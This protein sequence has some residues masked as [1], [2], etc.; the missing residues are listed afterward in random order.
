MRSIS[1]AN[2]KGGCGKTTTAIN[3]SACL[4]FS[5]KRVLL[6]DLDPQGHSTIGLNAHLEE[7]EKTIYDVLCGSNENTTRLDDVVLPINENFYFVPSSINLSTF[8]QELS[9]VPNRE[10]KL[11]ESIRKLR[12]S[13]EYIIIDCPPSLGLLTFNSIMASTEIFIPVDMGSFS[14]QGTRRLMDILEL[15]RERTGH[16]IEVKAIATMFDKRTRIAKEILEHIRDHFKG[17]LFSVIVNH[18]VKLKEAASFGKSIIDYDKRSQGFRDYLE[19]AAQVIEE[20]KAFEEIL[21]TETERPPFELITVKKRFVHHAPRAKSVCI[22]GSFN[23]WV[24][25]E[26]SRMDRAEDGTW[27]KTINLEPGEYQYKYVVD[28]TWVEDFR[29]PKA[30]TDPYGGKNSVIEIV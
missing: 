16:E 12:R 20:E 28:G 2:Q 1:I 27:S 18:N 29:N 4:A 3:L 17:S 23:N 5:G 8:E 30:F 25:T 24:P 15:V 6:I 21:P 9:G 7:P 19:L 14:L 26:E 22:V 10:T 11:K 13:F